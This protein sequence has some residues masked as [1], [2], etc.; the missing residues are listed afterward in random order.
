L[1]PFTTYYYQFNVCGT[2]I[3]SA[4]GRTKTAPS[5][6]D[7]VSAISLGVFSCANYP[8]GYFNAY[9][10]AARK[11]NIDYFVHLGDY[12]YEDEVGVPGEDERA[13]VPPKEI[14]SLYDY[15]T[16]IGQYRTDEDLLLAHQQ[17]AWITVWVSQ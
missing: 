2:E 8:L 13:M 6:D 3:K 11:D 1:S 12:I 4:I 5:E 16:R 7:D 15:R 14:V 9:G 17:F 10:N